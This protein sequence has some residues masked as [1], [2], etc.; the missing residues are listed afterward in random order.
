MLPQGMCRTHPRETNRRVRTVMLSCEMWGVR[1]AMLSCEMWGARTA[2]LLCEMRG[3]WSARPKSRVRLVVQVKEG[4]LVLKGSQ[5]RKGHRVQQD[6]RVQEENLVHVVQRGL[7]A[8]RKTVYL[9][10]L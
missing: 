8:I 7:L 10:H 4:R 9:H 1:T 5:D 2:M 3:A 6:H